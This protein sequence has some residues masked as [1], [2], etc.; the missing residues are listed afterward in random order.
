MF[1]NF[2]SVVMRYFGITTLLWVL[3]V[4]AKTMDVIYNDVLS[5][6][7][8][9]IPAQ[10]YTKPEVS[11]NHT[12]NPCY[13]CHT[14]SKRPNMLNDIDV[15]LNYVFPTSVLKNPWKNLFKDRSKLIADISDE[16]IL[17]YVRQ[18]NYFD[19]QGNIRLKKRLKD[20]IR[21]FDANNNNS[22]DGY[23]P[24]SYFNFDNQGFDRTPN[25]DYTGWRSYAYYPL[26]GSFMP[27][28]GSTDDVSIRLAPAF[29]QNEQGQF[30]LSI[31]KINMA[32]VEA[33]IMEQDVAIDPI[34]ENILGVDLDKNGVLGTAKQ[35]KYD[36]APLEKRFMSYVGKAKV[37]Q[38]HGNVHMAAKL[39]PEGTEFLHSV[40]YLDIDNNGQVKMAPRMKELRYAKKHS[41]MTY[42]QW[43]VIVNAEIKE[44]HDFPDRTKTV[45][46]NAEE[47]VNVAQGWN[48]QGFIEDY[49]GEL[50]PQT[51]EEQITCTGCH[52]GTGV[53]I[54]SNISFYRKLPHSSFQRGWYH[55]QQKPM[56]GV[57]EPKRESDGEYEYSYYLKHNPTG[58][59]FRANDE[60][61]AKFFN[62]NGQPREEMFNKLHQDIA[63]LML[64]TKQRALDLNKVYK[65]IVEE[66]SFKLGKAPLLSP[67]DQVVF[68][69]VTLNQETGI[70]EPLSAF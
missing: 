6:P 38:Q 32:I 69:E 46:G 59:E 43:E 2:P 19:E 62:E 63:V 48:Y 52:G 18:D 47:G 9:Y 35:V 58:D 36:W 34:D 12:V 24:D 4:S 57:P 1:F 65:T 42:Y 55:W 53:M 50:R 61:K 45:L 39:F 11:E 8:P 40:R 26:P 3:P 30:D 37:E 44:R 70:K 60:V 17:T 14:M 51:Y 23:V 5:H 68:K 28:N 67:A 56:Q 15:Q 33:M 27:T 21:Y 54:D 20:D 29:Q 25:G 49:Q 66:Q 16:Q 10:C 31:Y 13:A 7:S 64:P 41:W 22:W